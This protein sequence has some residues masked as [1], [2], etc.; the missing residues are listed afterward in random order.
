MKHFLVFLFFVCAFHARAQ[1]TAVKPTSNEFKQFKASTKTYVVKTGDKKFDTELISA[2]EDEWKITAF[3][4]I[5]SDAFKKKLKE[6]DKTVS[7]ILLANIEVRHSNYTR[8]Y[9]YLMLINGGYKSI[10]D[11]AYDDMIAYCPINH[12]VNEPENTDCYYRVRNMLQSMIG[13]IDLLSKNKI[14]GSGLNAVDQISEIYDKK[15][16]HIKDRTLLFCS[17]TMGDKLSEED[18]KKLYPYPFEIC[19]RQRLEKVIRE[20]STEYY[21]LQPGIT[22]NKSIFV[23][24]P[25]NG[26]VLYFAY[27]AMG[28]NFNKGN[29]KDLV[30]EIKD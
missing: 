27:Q 28:L 2:M 23:F 1:L 26:D 3:E 22:L 7:Y 17:E 19:N 8:E 24:D 4:E 20:K 16:T 14:K 18:I 6:K 12:F 21:Y 9:H 10:G 11:Y 5:S 30:E 15:A 13:V 29:L 25:S